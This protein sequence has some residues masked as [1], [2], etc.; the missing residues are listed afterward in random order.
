ME[1]FPWGS[2]D[3][4]EEYL[5]T[6]YHL[7]NSPAND[8]GHTI[9]HMAVHR[10]YLSLVNLL[11]RLGADLEAKTEKGET[12]LLI[13]CQSGSLY[14]T[15]AL[16]TAGADVMATNNKGL[17]CVHL[18]AS[19]GLVHLI[20]YLVTTKQ[21]SLAVKDNEFN[22]PL[23]YAVQQ[24]R[25]QTVKYIL[26]HEVDCLTMTNA[27]G[28]TPLHMAAQACHNGLCWKLVAAG[29]ADIVNIKDNKGQ[30]PVDLA[31]EYGYDGLA[32]QMT[33]WAYSKKIQYWGAMAV[34]LLHAFGPGL[35]FLMGMYCY[36]KLST[37]WGI[38]L[39]LILLI[40]G[41]LYP[42]LAFHRIVHPAKWPCPS[43]HGAFLFGI[44]ITMAFYYVQ[45]LPRVWPNDKY[46]AI[47]IITF[48]FVMIYLLY[49]IRRSDPGVNRHSKQSID[50]RLLT[51]TDVAKG[52]EGASYCIQ[53]EI[54]VPDYTKHCH[55][56]EHCVSG[57]DHH[58]QWLMKCIGHNNHRLF[59][60]L[61]FVV[62]MENLL[63]VIT[64]TS[65]IIQ[66]H[67]T[68]HP[69]K[70][71]EVTATEEPWLF[72]LIIANICTGMIAY[73]NLAFQLKYISLLGTTYFDTS[74]NVAYK[75]KR[76]SQNVT[77]KQRVNNILVFLTNYNQWY[78]VMARN[79]T[80]SAKL[81]STYHHI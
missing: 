21:V 66:V 13:A 81:S 18:S 74:G 22:T 64:A 32:R 34:F 46:L 15:H 19:G 62:A 23:H 67:S 6:H 79:K 47:T 39:A 2:A 1:K 69:L 30:T 31:N 52:E 8:R 7:I 50:G 20:H 16:V 9:L 58:C 78:Q 60:I 26:K 29:N 33:S 36:A 5:Q 80:V 70:L 49:L 76:S 10:N 3:Q 56:C 4:W 72:V 17:S 38:I 42:M 55:M 28:F 57:F 27:K 65:C 59:V 24:R 25:T 71:L 75:K 54:V 53:C 61:L 35:A 14:T 43:M 44:T 40:G 73:M 77:F 63:F 41:F 11:L 45:V 12:P 37:P 51:I 48:S 68:Y